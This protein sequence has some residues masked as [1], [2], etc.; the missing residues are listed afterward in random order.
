MDT[1][2][3]IRVETTQRL[4]YPQNYIYANINPAYIPQHVPN[5]YINVY[6][7]KPIVPLR[8]NG[9]ITF[10]KTNYQSDNYLLW[11]LSRHPSPVSHCWIPGLISTPAGCKKHSKKYRQAYQKIF[12]YGLYKKPLFKMRLSQTQ[13]QIA[14]R[15]QKK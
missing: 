15:S 10:V 7:L 2:L 12:S 11:D 9:P 5:N 6:H 13:K 1:S 3:K 14:S 8:E 4:T